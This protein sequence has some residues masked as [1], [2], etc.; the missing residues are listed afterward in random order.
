MNLCSLKCGA[1]LFQN[2]AGKPDTMSWQI[3]WW[4]FSTSSLI[5]W[6]STCVGE[7]QVSSEQTVVLFKSVHR[8][9]KIGDCDRARQNLYN[10]VTRLVFSNVN[11]IALFQTRLSV[12][13]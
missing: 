12:L 3:V 13:S 6:R 2:F 8:R 9:R 11:N 1:V 10:A 4:R 7:D 5:G